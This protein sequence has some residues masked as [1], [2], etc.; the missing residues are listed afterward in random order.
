[1]EVPSASLSSPGHSEL[2]F[3]FQVKAYADNFKF[4]RHPKID[5][6]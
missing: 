6:K 2:F 1:V 4:K 5:D 3:S